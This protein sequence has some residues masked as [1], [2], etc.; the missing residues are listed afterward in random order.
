MKI[1]TFIKGETKIINVRIINFIKNE[2]D[3][4]KEISQDIFGTFKTKGTARFLIFSNFIMPLFWALFII[5]LD[6]QFIP[7]RLIHFYLG[8]VLAIGFCFLLAVLI[9]FVPFILVFSGLHTSYNIINGFISI[10]K[11]LFNYNSTI[12]K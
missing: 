10:I 8:L 1:K 11:R 5:E 3:F 6:H 7:K 4:T 2:F 9:T 12:N